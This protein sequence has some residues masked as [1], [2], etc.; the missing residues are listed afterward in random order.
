MPCFFGCALLG[1]PRLAVL[2]LL[3]TGTYIHDAL[4]MHGLGMLAIL[5]G[6]FFLPWTTLALAWST[7]RTDG[8]LAT[9]SWILIIIA[10]VV[11]LGATK[12]GSIKV[13]RQRP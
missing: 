12:G 6:L 3:I 11:D 4:A 13:E 2:G 1:F 7:H 8:D 10:V 5:A 9:W